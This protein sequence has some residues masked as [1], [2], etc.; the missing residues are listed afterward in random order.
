MWNIFSAKFLVVALSNLCICHCICVLFFFP[1]SFL[2][3]AAPIASFSL[4][5]TLSH[6]HMPIQREAVNRSISGLYLYLCYFVSVSVSTLCWA[7][8]LILLLILC[9]VPFSL[10]LSLTPFSLCVG[11]CVWIL[12][13]LLGTLFVCLFSYLFWFFMFRVLFVSL[14]LS[15]SL[16][17]CF[18]FILLLSFWCFLLYF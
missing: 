17:L 14:S 5:H 3:Q 4:L 12:F 9:S 8:I 2:S 13:N 16:A 10:F 6:T 11:L 7:F 18:L 15:F 1:N